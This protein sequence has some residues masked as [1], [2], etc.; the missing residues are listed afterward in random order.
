MQMATGKRR[1]WTA[2]AAAGGMAAALAGALAALPSDAA[3]AAS[4]PTITVSRAC[5]VN[6]ASLAP[7]TVSG[8]G[9]TP[10]DSVQLAS[11]DLYGTVPQV[12]PDGTFTQTIGGAPLDTI[13]PAAK[14]EILKA[15]DQGTSTT[16]GDGATATA[17]FQIANLAVA[18]R[19]AQ[20]KPARKVTFSFSGFT[21]GAPI[22]AHYVRGRR[23]TATQRF[24]TAT[25]PCGM[26]SHRALL[27]PGGD[28]RYDRYTVQFD[29]A[30]R[31]RTASA[32]KLVSSI[33]L[34][35]F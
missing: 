12:R 33:Q 30:K 28:P 14:T 7:I 25:G 35:R 31:Y 29:D 15:T 19:P 5:Y 22:Y 10:G 20:S 26:L 1:H 9:W 16:T 27:Y 11:G 18:T 13:D 32:P 6:T 24:G 23:V 21:A 17:S 8:A 3:G 34:F 2:A 4:T